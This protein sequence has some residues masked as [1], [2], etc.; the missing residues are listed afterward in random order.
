ML[1][2]A[3]FQGVG[4]TPSFSSLTLGKKASHDSTQFLS[5]FESTESTSSDFMCPLV[6]EKLIRKRDL[7]LDK[8]GR[9]NESV[10][11]AQKGQQ[12]T[13]LMPRKLEFSSSDHA[14][15]GPLTGI[16]AL[17]ND[18]LSSTSDSQGSSLPCGQ[19]IREV[20]SPLSSCSVSP[21]RPLSP[22]GHEYPDL[23]AVPFTD[24]PAF[25]LSLRP[26]VRPKAKRRCK[27]FSCDMERKDLEDIDDSKYEVFSMLTDAEQNL[28][29]VRDLLVLAEE[30]SSIEKA[31]ITLKSIINQLSALCSEMSQTL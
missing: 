2:F 1:C 28:G 23:A 30:K 22:D 14:S 8:L 29:S 25:R 6:K 13:I 21:Q 12:E 4:D 18:V 31:S 16:F 26:E 20:P 7:L 19:V 15:D 10:V 5:S 11:K 17:E 24:S 3:G 27:C 9:M